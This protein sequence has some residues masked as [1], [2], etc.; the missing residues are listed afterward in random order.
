QQKPIIYQEIDGIRREIEG[1]YVRKGANRVGFKLAA[2]DTSRPLMIDPAL[3][4]STYLG[5]SGHDFGQGIAVDA[6]G[7]AYV[8]GHTSSTNF[9]TTLGAFQ[10]AFAG[11][12]DAFV[13]KLNP[14][15]SALVYSTYLGGSNGGNGTGGADTNEGAGIAVDADGNAYVTGFTGANDFPTTPGAFQSAFAGGWD[16]FV[17]KL[18]PTGSALVYSTYLGGSF[19]DGGSGIAVDSNGNTYVTGETQSSNFPTTVGAF[20]PALA[21]CCDAFVTKLNPTGSAL[22]YSTY[23]GGRFGETSRGIVTDAD[24]NVFVTGNTESPDFPT[25]MGAFQSIYGGNNDA[26]VTK[27]NPIGSGLVYSTYLGGTGGERGGG[28]AVDA[29]GNAYVTGSTWSLDFPTTP[30]AFQPNFRGGDF[31]AFV[32][33]FN[34]DGSLLVYSTYLGGSNGDYGNGIAVNAAGN[35]YVTG[36]TGPNIETRNCSPCTNDFPTTPGTFQPNYGG[37]IN[38]AYVVKLDPTGS[39]LAY[40]TYLGGSSGDSGKGIAVDT[41]GNAFVT[42]MTGICFTPSECA[43]NNFPTTAGAFQPTAGGGTSG[44]GDAF[45]AKIVDDAPPPPTTARFEQ[46]AASQIGSWTTYGSETG[47]FSGGTIVASNVAASTAMFSFT[48]TAVSWIGVK[49]NVCG[50]AARPRRAGQPHFRIGVLRFRSS[51]RCKSHDGDHRDGHEQ[52]RWC[53]RRNGRVRCD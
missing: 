10:I 34:P 9:P 28:I 38:D 8:T 3:S 20:Q 47:T 30:G 14:D 25:T 39:A 11:G 13:T 35:A 12:S 42:G 51:G 50:I 4:Y 24:G 44:G 31:D 26:F 29:N 37:G 1:R 22:V 2:Y 5:G 53:P 36:D 27:L 23:L 46:S 40:S 21:G 16:A 45:V 43:T 52:L 7:N 6:H 48:G 41:G 17:T 19:L 49:C 18:N 15:G 33:K 32:A